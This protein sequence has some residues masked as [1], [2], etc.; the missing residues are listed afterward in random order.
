MPRIVDGLRSFPRNRAIAFALALLPLLAIGTA[1]LAALRTKVDNPHGAD[2]REECALCH[3]AEGWKPAKVSTRFDHGKYGFRLDGAHAAAA[4]MS[5][6]TTLQFKQSKTQCQSCHEDPHR[7]EMGVDCSHCHGS[8]SFTDRAPMVRAHQ[9]TNF[10]LSGSH[11]SLDCESCHKPTAQGRMQFVNT[12][13]DCQSCH[14]E[15]Y[16]STREPDHAA[17]GFPTTCQTCHST[18]TWDTAK[19]NHDR[20]GFPLTGAHR[21]AACANCH[22]NGRYAGTASTCQ[23][24]HMTDYDGATP[25]HASSGFAASACATCH[26]TTSFAGATFDHNSSSFPLTGSHRTATCNSCHSS[27]VYNGLNTACQA[28]H[29]TDYNAATPNHAASGFAASACATCHNTTSFAGATFDH[30]GTSFPLTGAHQAAACN[31]CHSSGVYNGL[32]TACQS[33]HMADYNA[34]TPNHASAGFAASACAT[35]HGTTT[36]TGATFN[37]NTTSFPLTGAH[38]T[39]ACSSCHSSGVYNGLNTACQ[40][41]HLTEYNS[42]TPNHAAAGFAA[43]ACATCH[44]TTQW[45]GATFNHDASWFPIY[46]GRHR[47]VW[48]TNC[49]TCHTNS[50]NFAVF[51]CL[52][53]HPHDDRAVTDSHHQGRSGYSYDSNACY[54]CHPTGRAG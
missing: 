29:M 41:C 42:A 33:C 2:F 40:S 27:G 16:R 21:A 24:C 25:N 12:K 46:S 17:G 47:T 13:A 30:N 15:Q 18:L 1:S 50:S 53:C 20:T 22:L 9:L 11:A 6:H 52:S 7:G 3:S 44:N 39:A 34:A 23:S 5:C 45:S 28:C 49:A 8:R 43:S 31:S 37:H 32:N 54:R 26:N 10:P 38:T 19:F 14:M 48:G 35:C 4:C 51:T 36:W